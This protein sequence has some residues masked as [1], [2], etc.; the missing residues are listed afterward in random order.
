MATLFPPTPE[1]QAII[2]AARDSTSNLM[3][4]ALAGTGKT[5]ALKLAVPHIPSKSILA[6]AFN[7]K[8]A[9]DLERAFCEPGEDGT[10]PL[11]PW[12]VA[13]SFNAL[14]HRALAS[15]TG[16]R[17]ILDDKKIARLTTAYTKKLGGV[18]DDEWGNLSNL[19]KRA[20][21]LGLVPQ[22]YP[23]SRRSL[24]SDDSWGWESA[25]NAI[26]LDLTEA[27]M[28]G[29]RQILSEAIDLALAGTIDYDDQIYMSTLFH[30][31]YGKFHTVIC[32]ESQ[33]ISHLNRIQLMKSCGSR[34]IIAGDQ[35][36][37]IY[38][39]RGADGE[40]MARIRDLKPDWI[41]LPLTVTWRCPKVVV[42]RQLGHA[43]QYTAA[44]EAPDGALFDLRSEKQWTIGSGGILPN[45]ILCRN[46]APLISL[47]FS[48]IRKRIGIKIL[49]R[50]FGKSLTTLVKKIAGTTTGIDE[51][52]PKFTLWRDREMRLA[53]AADKPEKGSRIEDQYE[54]IM[55]VIE[56]SGDITT[57]HHIISCLEQLFEAAN[58]QIILS[59]GHKAKGLE[60]HS[61][62]HL[63][64][65]RIPSK[66]AQ[67][68]PIALEQEQNLAYVIETR[69]KHTLILANLEQF[70]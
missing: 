22:K 28:V 10:A 6:L 56:S 24:L 1:Q 37:G 60:W 46:N 14:G 63:D 36:Q 30:G 9:Q 16:R 42:A 38:A 40:S 70:I 61:V 67:S 65:W 2:E 4:Y 21:M 5:T 44:P 64:P 12:V 55:A 66:W 39:F 68:N 45:A 48:L 18:S 26:N 13:R 62:L 35:K 27:L 57:I 33:D 7:K 53:N 29:A 51:F 8:N 47:A 69:A 15:A 17:L 54:S 23:Q 3:I 20:K 25:A 11:A 34:L 32:D 52:I 50:D 59:T 58:G 41:D 31:M 43:P 19:V 49:G